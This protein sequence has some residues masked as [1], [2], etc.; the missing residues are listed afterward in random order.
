MDEATWLGI[1][2]TLEE[3]DA[4]LLIPMADRNRWNCYFIFAV[5]DCSQ[6]FAVAI[7]WY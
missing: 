7:P 4:L 3:K 1:L 6:D 2:K 5:L